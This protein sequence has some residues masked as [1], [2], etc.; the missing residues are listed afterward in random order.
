M[1]D[2]RTGCAAGGGQIEEKSSGGAV[3]KCL[4]SQERT[5]GRA[6]HDTS[7]TSWAQTKSA[8]AWRE[9]LRQSH[10][11][12]WLSDVAVRPCWPGGSPFW[13]KTRLI[14]LP[15]PFLPL[16]ST[17]SSPVPA[18]QS[19][20]LFSTAFVFKGPA[21]FLVCLV[22]YRLEACW[23]VRPFISATLDFFFRNTILSP[24]L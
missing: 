5:P 23:R 22:L 3:G 18:L 19:F 11:L 20:S 7:E 2:A 17:A 9:W 4:A 1:R 16:P 12:Q 8:R 21:A 24:L 10:W 14:Q 6:C 13:P 15:L